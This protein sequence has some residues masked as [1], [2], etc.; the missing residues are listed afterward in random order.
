MAKQVQ[1]KLNQTSVTV[2]E[3]K[4]GEIPVKLTSKEVEENPGF[5]RLLQQLG[6]QLTPDGVSVDVHKD[7]KQAEENLRH[8]KHSWLQSQLLHREMQEI[9]LDYDLKGRDT[10]L[11][12]AD[13]EF[14]EILEQCLNYAEAED[15]L[16]FSPDLGSNVS[17]LGLTP[18]DVHTYNPYK[19]EI[20]SM[21]QKL[22]PELEDRLRRKC[23]NLVSVF[24]SS[25]LTDSS[26]LAKAKASQLPAIVERSLR[27][28]EE[29]KQHLKITQEKREKQFWTYFQTLLDSLGML[30]MLVNQYRL[31]KQALN[32]TVTVQYL[33]TRCDALCLKIK[34]LELQI[35]CDTYTA[36]TVAA[37]AKIKG[38]LEERTGAKEKEHHRVDLALKAYADVGFG[39]NELA[40]EYGQLKRE[41]ENKHWGLRELAKSK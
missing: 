7:L 37:L 35:L 14:K 40:E 28:M 29:E 8:E 41:L 38:Y 21:Q 25:T 5:V 39:F 23:E 13:Y 33:A 19:K 30:E 12:P 6:Q 27:V 32:S 24:H 15:Y 34:N 22:I 18:A 11:S 17:L 26:S 36:E 1:F 20:P 16:Y 31:G 4:I 2:P 3:I 10:S 9:I